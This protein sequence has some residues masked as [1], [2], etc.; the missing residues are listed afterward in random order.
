MNA[1]FRPACPVTASQRLD[2]SPIA[3]GGLPLR[4]AC[5]GEVRYLDGDPT[6]CSY[7]APRIFELVHVDT[8]AGAIA[9][10]ERLARQ[11]RL[12]IRDDSA[13]GFKARLFIVRDDD[14]CQVLAGEPD[15]HGIRWCE[16]VASDG[17]ARFVVAQ[18][19]RLRAEAICEANADHH[20]EARALRFSASVLEGRL[21]H[22]DWR[23]TTRIAL[24]LERAGC[25]HPGIPPSP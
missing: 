9:A 6:S 19:C 22:A 14:D 17:E 23:V 18:A 12:Y 21:V 5:L 13:I 8:L 16:P 10:I 1:H 24:K 7:E 2:S 11:D 3:V 20:A 25:T 15:G 4:I